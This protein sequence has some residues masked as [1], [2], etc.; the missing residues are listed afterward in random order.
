MKTN[1]HQL[2]MTFGI[3][4]ASLHI[5]WVIAILTGVADWFMEWALSVH[6]VEFPYTIIDPTVTGTVALVALT[7]VGGYIIGWL[8]ACVWNWLEKRK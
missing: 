4:T 5:I 2:G 7:F 6:F 3:V 1:K 8:L